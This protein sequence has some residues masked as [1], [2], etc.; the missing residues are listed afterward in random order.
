MQTISK[1]KWSNLECLYIKLLS[2]L[3]Q[4]PCNLINLDQGN[5]DTKLRTK[6]VDARTR[7]GMFD[8]MYTYVVKILHKMIEVLPFDKI[9]ENTLIG[10]MP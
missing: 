9:I 10:E 2:D 3:V 5:Q 8:T 6:G 1:I 7:D 4:C